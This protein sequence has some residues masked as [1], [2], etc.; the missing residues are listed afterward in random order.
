MNQICDGTN[1]KHR[2]ESYF[3]LREWSETTNFCSFLSFRR[4]QGVGGQIWPKWLKCFNI[5]EESCNKIA[6]N[7][8]NSTP[9]IP[10]DGRD[11]D[12]AGDIVIFLNEKNYKTKITWSV[13]LRI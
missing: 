13:F 2:K 1:D 6:Q 11:G 5:S 12:I 9:N 3:I 8:N 7:D 4:H 10:N